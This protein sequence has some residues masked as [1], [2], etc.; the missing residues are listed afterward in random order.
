MAPELSAAHRRTLSAVCDTI[1]PSIDREDDPHGFWALSAADVGADA[2]FADLLA[3]VPAEQLAGT[4]ALLEGLAAQGFDELS[5]DDRERMMI[6]VA[7]SGPEEAA[8]IGSLIGGTILLTYAV[9]DPQTGQNPTW[10]AFGYPGPIG[11]PASRPKAIEPLVPEGDR[12]TLEADAIVVGSGSGGGVVAGTLAQ[13]GMKVVVLEAGGYFDESDF[14]MLELWGYQNLYYRGGPVPT[15]DG[16]VSLQAGSNLGGGTTINW[17]NCL[18]TTPWVRE[19]WAGEFGLEGVDGPEY[20]RHLDAVL[21]RIGANEDCSD[22][23][24]P[25]LRLKEGAEKLGWSFRR[26]VRNADPETY[27]PRPPPTWPS[28]T[29]AA[30]SRPASRRSCA[31]R[32]RTAPRSSCGRPRPGC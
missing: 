19:Q 13:S 28:A 9:P 2:A 10:P 1:V 11:A 15:A 26:L 7:L 21:G 23:N 18:R 32:S 12:M 25:T 3:T 6:D 31:T 4:I 17:T 27:S 5:R 24:G 22:Y 16:N 8:G 29:R 14:N 30:R 20:D